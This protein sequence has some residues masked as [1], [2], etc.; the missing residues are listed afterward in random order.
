MI[1][2]HFAHPDGT[3]TKAQGTPGQTLMQLAV[4]SSIAE[5]LAE[6]GGACACATCRVDIS[7]DAPV[8][9]MVEPEASMVD[10]VAEPLPTTRL[11]CQIILSAQMDGMT[12]HLPERQY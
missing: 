1:T 12:V 7:L 11:S 9:P 8:L 5:I 6:C 4:D 2:I 3:V 10:C